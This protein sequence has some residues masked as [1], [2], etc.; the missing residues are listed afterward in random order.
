M[1]ASGIARLYVMLV[2]T[3]KHRQGRAYRRII[4]LL[5][6]IND[7]VNSECSTVCDIKYRMSVYGMNYTNRK[8]ENNEAGRIEIG[9]FA[10]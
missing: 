1:S 3:G 10:V 5:K 7:G 8:R 4:Y 2:N 9:Y 6:R